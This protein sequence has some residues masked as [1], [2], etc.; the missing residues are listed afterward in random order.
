MATVRRDLALTLALAFPGVAIAG[1]VVATGMHFLMGW[2]WIGASLFGVLIA[3]T[4]PVSVIAAFK[5]VKVDRRLSMTV[6]NESLLNDAAAAVGFTLVGAIAA[7]ASMGSGAIAW[8]L[9]W[10]VVGGI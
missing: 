5:E 8:A 1:A 10:T 7:G 2:S 9:V 6:E 3:A 4:D